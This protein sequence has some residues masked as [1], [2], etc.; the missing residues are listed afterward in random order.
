MVQQQTERCNYRSLTHKVIDSLS[1]IQALDRFSYASDTICP[2]PLPGQAQDVLQSSQL[3][4]ENTGSWPVSNKSRI[5]PLLARNLLNFLSRYITTDI[6][7]FCDTLASLYSNLAK[8][9]LDTVIFNYQLMKS[10]GVAGMIGLTVNYIITARLLRAVT[11]SFGRLAAVEA[12][13]EVI[14]PVDARNHLIHWGA[15][16]DRAIFEQPIR[17]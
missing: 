5:W 10:I 13:L 14:R 12:K 4:W 3:G 17:V 9:L 8:P 16:V 15:L 7:K 11:P 6:A 1:A 2:W